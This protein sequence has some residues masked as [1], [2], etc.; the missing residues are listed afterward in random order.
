MVA[1][2]V[3]WCSRAHVVRQVK[4]EWISFFYEVS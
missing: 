2:F 1:A 3:L 4:A